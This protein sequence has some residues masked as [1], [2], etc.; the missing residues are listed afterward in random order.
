MKYPLLRPSPPRLSLL[1]GAL[2]EIER[3]GTFSNYGPINSELERRFIDSLFRGVGSCVTVCNAT[4]G[5]MLSIKYAVGRYYGCELDEWPAARKYALMPAFA[6]AA[7]PHAALWNH[8]RPLFCDVDPIS[9]LPCMASQERLLEEFAGEVAVVVTYATFGNNL[10]LPPYLALS[11]RHDLPIVVDAAASLGSRDEAGGQFGTGFKYPVVYSMH[12]TKTFATGEAGLIYCNDDRTIS[13]LRVMGNFG[14]GELRSATMPGLNSKLTEVGA[15][16]CL[17]KLEEIDAILEWRQ[18]LA[19][20]YRQ[21]LPELTFQVMR[22]ERHAYQFMPALLPIEL[23]RN[24]IEVV[25]RLAADG[26]VVGTYFS[27]HLAEQPY[28][29][30]YARPGELPIA[31]RI[32]ARIISLPLYDSMTRPDVDRICESVRRVVRSVG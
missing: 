27:P 11:S 7:I 20:A 30:K 5:L 6:F 13:A 10:D 22:G 26:I 29:T 32:G 12:A 16:L 14:F 24:R 21:N 25:E 9:W 1:G 17:K 3:S 23:N 18:C 2:A 28:F 8:L 4:I 31:D 19:D 15:L